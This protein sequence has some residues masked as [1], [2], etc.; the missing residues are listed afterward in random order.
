M[1][2]VEFGGK[3][4]LAGEGLHYEPRWFK[5]WPAD[6]RAEVDVAG[7]VYPLGD[8]IFDC[9]ALVNFGL[10]AVLLRA[11]ASGKLVGLLTRSDTK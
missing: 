2:C 6:V 11:I 10:V 1:V 9:H 8:L 7:E 3:Q 5:R 4:H